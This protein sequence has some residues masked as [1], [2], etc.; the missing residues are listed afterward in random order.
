MFVIDDRNYRDV[1]KR[2]EDRGYLPGLNPEPP[3]FSAGTMSHLSAFSESF[4]L[5]PRSEWPDRIRARG[6]NTLARL[7]RRHGIPTFDQDGT[8]WCWGHAATKAACTCL[9][10]QGTPKVLAPESVA[11]PASGWRNVGGTLTEAFGQLRHGGACTRDYVLKANTV[12]SNALKDGWQENAAVH[13]VDETY[14]IVGRNLWD[15]IVTAHFLDFAVACGVYWWSHALCYLDPVL[16][17]SGDVGI[18]HDN[19]H[20]SSYGED[21]LAV[22][23]ESRGTPEEGWG[24]IACRSVKYFGEVPPLSVE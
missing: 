12:R 7:I 8:K 2:A 17:E 21:G 20:G 18:L 16:L 19:S 13:R 14:A 6:D 5:I 24:V 3:E 23:T 22:F 9:A 15:Q 4:P 1:M 10:V 11:G